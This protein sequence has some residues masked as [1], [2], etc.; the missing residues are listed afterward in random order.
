MSYTLEMPGRDS[1]SGGG[2]VEVAAGHG[3]VA[4]QFHGFGPVFVVHDDGTVVER[5][6]MPAEDN[7]AQLPLGGAA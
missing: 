5:M 1:A 7:I 2:D 6:T 3:W 4:V